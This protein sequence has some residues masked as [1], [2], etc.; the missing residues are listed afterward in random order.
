MTFLIALPKITY[1]NPYAKQCGPYNPNICEATGEPAPHIQLV[2]TVY[3]SQYVFRCIAKN[4]HLD[5]LGNSKDNYDVIDFHCK[6]HNVLMQQLVLF[7]PQGTQA[8]VV[9]VNLI[10]LLKGT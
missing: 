4:I 3:N 7:I 9:V 10:L 5:N 1:P 8:P 6:Y 2:Q